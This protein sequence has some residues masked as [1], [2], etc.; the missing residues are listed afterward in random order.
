MLKRTSESIDGRCVV[1]ASFRPQHYRFCPRQCALIHVEDSW[2][3]NCL[4]AEGRVMSF[5]TEQ[6]RFL[7]RVEGRSRATSC[8]AS[9]SIR[10][11]NRGRNRKNWR[12]P[13][14]RANSPINAPFS[15]GTSANAPRFPKKVADASRELSLLSTNISTAA[16]GRARCDLN[17]LTAYQERKHE[18]V[19]HPFL[20]KI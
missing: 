3:E 9:G 11:S 19:V 20:E 4:T 1:G 6:G 13:S 2:G 17:V 16:L 8:C 10:R 5:F 18:E 14:L 12:P 15:S 7:A